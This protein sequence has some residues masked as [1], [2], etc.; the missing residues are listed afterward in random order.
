[1]ILLP[2][3][4]I[5]EHEVHHI[6]DEDVASNSATMCLPGGEDF[7]FIC[8]HP[9]PP[10]LVHDSTKRDAELVMVGCEVASN[11]RPSTCGL[12]ALPPGSRLSFAGVQAPG[13]GHP[14]G[15]RFGH[16]A[17]T[18]RLTYDPDAASGQKQTASAPSD[19]DQATAIVEE[20]E[21]RKMRPAM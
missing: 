16:R 14:R 7:D 13:N 11:S 8:L 15:S 2:R 21:P 3:L 20:Q 4:E 6:V 17:V 9:R 19:R 12:I 18:A 10:R 5:T 1:M